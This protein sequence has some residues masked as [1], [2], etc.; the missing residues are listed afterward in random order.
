MV[1]LPKVESV[2]ITKTRS[3]ACTS[4]D[5]YIYNY[6]DFYYLAHNTTY[7]GVDVGSSLLFVGQAFTSGVQFEVYRSFTYFDTST[8]PVGLSIT[9][10]YLSLYVGINASDT[11]FNVTIQNGQ[12][13]YPHEP[14]STT[15]F[16]Q[17]YYSGNGGSSNTSTISALNSYWNIS[18]ST[19]GM[20]WINEGGT[21]KFCLRSSRDINYTP[22]PTGDELIGIGSSEAGAVY[23]PTLY[24][25]YGVEG[26]RYIVHGPYYE[27]GSVAACLVNLTLT[28]TNNPVNSTVFLNGTDGVADTVT[29]EIE[30][31]G[32]TL[33]WNISSYNYSRVIYFTSNSFE[34]LYIYV[35]KPSD[36]TYVYYFSIANLVGFTNGYLSSSI[37]IGGTN[38]IVER[39]STSILNKIP[40][41][42]VKFSTY[43][44]SLTCNL[45]TLNFGS[46]V[47]EDDSDQGLV[48]ESSNFPVS[49]AG[50]NVTATAERLN[51]TFIQ[52]N[53]TD[54]EALTSWV[55][56]TF[57]HKVGN[58][59]V[60]DYTDNQTAN[61]V[62]WNWNSAINTT[63]YYVKVEALRSGTTSTWNYA[64]S[65][66]PYQT[67]PW[68]GVFDWMGNW[69]FPPENLVAFLLVI[70]IFSL[71]SFANWAFG[72]ILGTFT[73]MFFTYI[74]WLSIMNNAV[75][76]VCLS[77]AFL[78]SILAILAEGKR[79]TR[80]YEGL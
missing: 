79:E 67:N 43:S 58:V 64:C 9:S 59:F 45:G 54:N 25:S 63:S 71:F 72:A 33:A 50:L 39:Y 53:Y 65:A 78:V 48:V 13:T 10:A 2:T 77:F 15:D 4:S 52:V 60:T 49:V 62:Q 38:R 11:D 74:N 6:S 26:Y 21:T 7:G 17:I 34:E 40:F 8:L 19:D 29:Y 31:A 69:P 80:Y 51:S 28:I 76:W 36:Y 42:M 3:F 56:V 66:P 30:Q 44:L 5:N 75:G 23:A 61:T 68:T 70:V 12:P 27:D 1:N 35:P 32:I 20:G 24:V 22:Y 18:L 14:T 41:W 37:N 57:S 55:K 46:F 16:N 47:P 73:A